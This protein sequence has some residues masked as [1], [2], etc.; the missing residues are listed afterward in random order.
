VAVCHKVLNMLIVKEQKV[1]EHSR[2]NIRLAPEIKTRIAR[3]ATILGQDLT[4]FASTTLNERADEVIAKNDVFILSEK[5]RRA[6]LD[7]LSGDF[8]WETSEKSRKL[9]AEYKRGNTKGQTYEF[10]D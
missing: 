6:F 3:A 1:K 9:A 2:L 10:A 4:E 8:D 5:D 7:I